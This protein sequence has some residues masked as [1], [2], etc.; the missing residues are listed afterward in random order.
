MYEDLASGN[1]V[2]LV[3]TFEDFWIFGVRNLRFDEE[4][5]VVLEG[6]S[7]EKWMDMAHS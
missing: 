3:D 5:Y 2:F 7:E 6:G 1:R 4:M